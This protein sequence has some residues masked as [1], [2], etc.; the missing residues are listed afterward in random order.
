MNLPLAAAPLNFL[1]RPAGASVCAMLV[2]AGCA[3]A[4]RVPAEADP[5]G[6]GAPP[7]AGQTDRPDAAPEDGR[8]LRTGREVLESLTYAPLEFE[9][10]QVAKRSLRGVDVLH[11]ED[12]ALPLVT[13][14]A[15]FKGGYGLFER[16][17]YAAAMGLPALLRYGG[18]RA[19]SPDEVDETLDRHA[20]QL[21]FGTAGGSITSSV[22][23]LTEHVEAALD[24]WGDLL[25]NPGFSEEEI[26]T[27]RGRQLESV[28]RRLDDP[29]LL[30]FSELNRLLYGDHPIGWEM[31]EHDLARD[32]LT[33]ERFAS[34]HDRV[35]CRE[36]LVLGVTGDGSWAHLEP[37]LARLLDRLPSCDGELPAPPLPS[38][39]RG[40]GVFL[41]E[42][43]LEQAVIVMAHPTSVRLEDDDEYYAAMIG[44]SILG[45]GG[46]SSRMMARLRTEEGYAYSASSLWTTPRRYDGLV[47]ATTRT[48]PENVGPAIDVILETM[49]SLRTSPPSPDEV[50]TTVDQIVNGF[51]FNFDTPGQIVSRSMF[52]LAQDLPADWLERYWRGVQRVS[53][54]SVRNVFAE[55]LRP[56]E[57]TILVV[58]DPE[59]I[60]RDELRRFGA[61]S[62][63]EVR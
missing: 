31:D 55:H 5:P 63:I 48:R 39:R 32:R 43:D 30:A 17:E 51:V 38:I 2:L 25:A 29:G 27:W 22:N 40:G 13:V 60:G 8:P 4:G 7:P 20:L 44:N 50:S 45:S 15:H 34:V 14:Y 3:S 6:P 11:L 61:L 47:G 49:D 58:G 19:R 36:N 52:Y 28:R 26:E 24:L 33:P 16:E 35:A 59:R 1:P 23:A 18:T 37:L 53:P 12:H 21:S 41:I 54:E 57:M 42:R 9:Q 62:V 10:P 46:F 56:G